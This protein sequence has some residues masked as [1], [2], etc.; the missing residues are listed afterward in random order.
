MKICKKHQT[1][2]GVRRK[3]SWGGVHSVVYGGHLC[4]VSIIC[5][6]TIWR[7]VHVSKP[8]VWRSFL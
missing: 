1:F 2:R 4:L 8:T 5:D 6:V 7:H 3:F